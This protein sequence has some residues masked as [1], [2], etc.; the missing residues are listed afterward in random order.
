MLP[1]PLQNVV[2]WSRDSLELKE[3]KGIIH[4]IEGNRKAAPETRHLRANKVHPT[5]DKV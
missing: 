4:L 3:D 2:R 1:F 5:Q